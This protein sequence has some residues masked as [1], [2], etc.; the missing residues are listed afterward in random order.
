M[1]RYGVLAGMQSARGFVLKNG[2]CAR[3]GTGGGK[4]ANANFMQGFKV[5]TAGIRAADYEREIHIL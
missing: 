1:G 4:V 3:F 2:L 5:A